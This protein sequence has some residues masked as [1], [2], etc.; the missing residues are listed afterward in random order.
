MFTCCQLSSS[1]SFIIFET[2]NR[3]LSETINLSDG[4]NILSHQL[5]FNRLIH[6]DMQNRK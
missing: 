6:C 1:A 5:A 2:N 3:Y 4:M